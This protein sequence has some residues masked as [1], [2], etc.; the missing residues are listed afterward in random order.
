MRDQ[1]HAKARYPCYEVVLSQINFAGVPRSMSVTYT[2]VLEVS[3][4]SVLFLSALLCA[5]RLRRC[6]CRKYHPRRSRQCAFD[7]SLCLHWNVCH[8]G[9]GSHP[10]QAAQVAGRLRTVREVR[11]HGLVAGDQFGQL[12]LGPRN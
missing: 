1:G 8:V 6:A 9:T 7:R 5:E 12:M 10:L 11:L 3:E 4:D 2:A